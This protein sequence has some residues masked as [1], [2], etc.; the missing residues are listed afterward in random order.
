MLLVRFNEPFSFLATDYL[1][2]GCTKCLPLKSVHWPRSNT[3]KKY[4][5]MKRRTSKKASQT[6]QENKVRAAHG[7]CKPCTRTCLKF[8]LPIL[9]AANENNNLFWTQYLTPRQP[10]GSYEGK[11]QFTLSPFTSHI[12]LWLKREKIEAER[13]GKIPGSGL[14]SQSSTSSSSYIVQLQHSEDS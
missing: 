14:G 7:E 11:S 6:M 13:K 2:K 9:H 4:S 10:C 1:G 5:E 8:Y 12:T 3:R